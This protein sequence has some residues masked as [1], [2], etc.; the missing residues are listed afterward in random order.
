MVL[1]YLPFNSLVW[2]PCCAGIRHYKE[3]V[4]ET[5]P[6]LL[7]V[8]SIGITQAAITCGESSKFSTVFSIQFSDTF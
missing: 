8:N 6:A 7:P 2:H 5:L 3:R 4:F 1:Y